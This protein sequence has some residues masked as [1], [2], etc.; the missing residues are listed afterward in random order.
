MLELYMELRWV[1]H[2]IN[3]NHNHD[4]ETQHDF[5]INTYLS[6]E[7]SL[8]N[9]KDVLRPFLRHVALFG[10]SNLEE[11]VV[12]WMI[13]SSRIGSPFMKALQDGYVFRIRCTP[14]WP[15]LFIWAI[16]GSA[17][18]SHPMVQTAA[19]EH[20]GGGIN[21][22]GKG[23]KTHQNTSIESHYGGTTVLVRLRVLQRVFPALSGDGDI[24]FRNNGQRR[25]M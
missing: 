24:S 3:H 14:Q 6:E 21:D 8:A 4:L 16:M 7:A 25:E 22:F 2:F 18:G 13:N 17:R 23:W 11:A 1:I 10:V 19:P 15:V 20:V 9:N 12:S 5:S